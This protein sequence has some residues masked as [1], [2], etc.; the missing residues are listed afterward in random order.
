MV[1]QSKVKVL[2]TLVATTANGAPSNAVKIL[3]TQMELSPITR[4]T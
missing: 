2:G 4:L 1:F 3:R